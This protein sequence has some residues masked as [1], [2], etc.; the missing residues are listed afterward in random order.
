MNYAVPSLVALTL[1]VCGA[2]ASLPLLVTRI[3]PKSQPPLAASPL[4]NPHWI[5]ESLSPNPVL[6]NLS[7]GGA[8]R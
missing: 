4:G 8:S 2:V 1:L 7:E 5:V 6:L 3:V